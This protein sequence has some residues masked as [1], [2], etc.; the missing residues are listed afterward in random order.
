VKASRGELVGPGDPAPIR[1]EGRAPAVLAIHGFG[2]TPLEIELV[3]IVAGRLGRRALA[4][5]LPGHGT[6]A[7]DL[8]R[9]RWDDW[10]RAAEAALDEVTAGGE[11]AVV[12]GLSLGSLLATHLAVTRAER[13]RALGLLANAFWLMSPFPAWALAAVDRFRIPD[14]RMPKVAADI[15]DPEARR[16]HLTYGQ[17]PVHAAVEVQK[18]GEMMR[19]RLPEVRMP[20]LIV[21]GERDRVCP[22]ANAARVAARIGSSDVKVVMLPQSRHI[23]TRDIDRAR[24]AAELTTF[25]Q[26]FD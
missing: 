21:H 15:A 20:T 26:R 12:F 19:R 13:V 23:L 5:L 24:V 4:P 2:G 16:T 8:A 11:P 9:M 18:A 22:A 25:V 17:H 3:T 6:H 1:L 14:F 10:A 7:D